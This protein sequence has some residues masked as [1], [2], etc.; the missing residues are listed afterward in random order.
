VFS[1]ISSHQALS[2]GSFK[3]KQRYTARRASTF[4]KQTSPTHMSNA[5]SRQHYQDRP[6]RLLCGSNH[7]LS[8]C[9]NYERKSFMERMTFVQLRGLCD[10]CLVLGHRPSLCPKLRICWVTGCSRN[11]SSFLHPEVSAKPEAQVKTTSH[12]T[13]QTW[14]GDQEAT[15][16]YIKGRNNSFNEGKCNV[17][18][19]FANKP[20]NFCTKLNWKLVESLHDSGQCSL[21]Y[22]LIVL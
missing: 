3:T 1:D 7:W 11:H 16:P 20:I 22:T 10:N 15:S 13:L 14:D 12:V 6:K 8:H 18:Y 21:M 9:S 4:M 2:I 5:M 17:P 19:L